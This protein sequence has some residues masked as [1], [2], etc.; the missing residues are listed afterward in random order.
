MPLSRPMPA[1]GP[2]VYELRLRHRSG[3]YRVV[4]ALGRR[5]VVHVLHAF[6][7]ATQATSSRDIDLARERLKE[8]LR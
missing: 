4:Y 5:G 1:I 6:K 3:A 7:K 8:V 2:G